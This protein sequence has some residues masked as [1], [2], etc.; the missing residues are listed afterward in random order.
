[1][2]T[3]NSQTVA[4][5]TEPHSYAEGLK[6]TTEYTQEQIKVNNTANGTFANA[7]N[8]I[9]VNGTNGTAGDIPAAGPSYFEQIGN[10]LSSIKN[11]ISDGVG[12]GYAYTVSTAESVWASMPTMTNA[13]GMVCGATSGVLLSNTTTSLIKEYREGKIKSLK[14]FTNDTRLVNTVQN[15]A[16]SAGLLALGLYVAEDNS[17]VFNGF[18]TSVAVTAIHNASKPAPKRELVFVSV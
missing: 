9:P 15:V 2:S 6:N 3:V 5:A 18:V 13:T 8:D 17:S 7:T 16:A 4:P 1:M 10:Y 12:A 14:D 11:S